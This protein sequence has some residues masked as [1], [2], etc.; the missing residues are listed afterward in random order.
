MTGTPPS[1]GSF[2]NAVLIESNDADE[3]VTRV[4]LFIDGA[5]APTAVP[6]IRSING[7]VTSSDEN[8]EPR[9]DIRITGIYSVPSRLATQIVDYQWEILEKPQGSSV[10]LSSTT[11]QEIGFLYDRASILPGGFGDLIPGIGGGGGQA[12]GIDLAGEY[13]IK[14][15]VTDDQGLTSTNAGT[16]TFSAIPGDALHIQMSWDADATDVDLWLQRGGNGT[17]CDRFTQAEVDQVRGSQ[18]PPGQN[19]QTYCYWGN[20]PDGVDMNADGQI[21]D[22]DDGGLCEDAYLDIDNTSGFGPENINI[23]SPI[24]GTYNVGIHYFAGGLR[25]APTLNSF[26]KIFVNGALRLD[27]SNQLRNVN[28]I[29]RIAQVNW[30][31]GDAVITTVNSVAQPNCN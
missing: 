19:S 20:C 5:N 10:Q 4:P 11:G 2:S 17:F 13:T 21:C 18:Q 14:L 23:E 27:L 15:T 12:P 3:Q 9:D 16:L 1:E 31:N 24:D 30:V 28:D 22:P 26:V 7:L 6:Q 25:G 8:L 29:W